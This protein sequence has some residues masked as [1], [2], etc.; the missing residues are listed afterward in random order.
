MQNQTW[1]GFT[2]ATAEVIM[3]PPE[4]PITSNLPDSDSRITGAM[5]DGG[6]SPTET[7]RLHIRVTTGRRATLLLGPYLP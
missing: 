1:G 3:L 4:P 5:E 7:V 6:C 2:E